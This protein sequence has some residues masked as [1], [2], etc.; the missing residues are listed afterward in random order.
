MLEATQLHDGIGLPPVCLGGDV[1]GWTAD[2]DESRA[3]LDA[4]YAAGI[5]F[6][7]TSDVYAAWAHEGLG[8]QSETIIGD[9]MS[10]R[11]VR[12]EMIVASKVGWLNIPI[13]GGIRPAT[14]RRQIDRSLGR[15]RTDHLD[16]Y[17]AHRDDLGDLAESLA[18]F[19]DL[20]DAGKIRAYGLSNISAARLA[21]AI[22]I[23]TRDGLRLP[24][25]L[26]PKYSLME[27]D[28]ELTARAV[29]TKA[30]LAVNPY[31]A[32]ASG[33]LTGKYRI[34]TVPV[35][36]DRAAFAAGYLRDPRGMPVLAALDDIA[37]S[38][39]VPVAS[40]ALS[41]LRS[42]PTVVAPIVSART[43]AHVEPIARSLDLQLDSAELAALEYV[44]RAG[45]PEY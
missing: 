1:F 38:H 22:S 9:W 11:G 33:F 13:I 32:L 23:C 12:D 29:A 36:S 25:A 24:A 18:A 44:S 40:V 17:Y 16:L 14:I 30:G 4:A 31:S 45:E 43:P 19:S 2:T 20:V 26:Q 42:Q 15:L 6:L 35:E 27:R 10:D 28:Y 37:S 39:R 8:G 41:W 5:R 3:V 34:G 7:D 21:E